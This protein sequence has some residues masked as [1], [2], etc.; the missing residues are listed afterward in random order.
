MWLATLPVVLYMNQV[1]GF[2]DE[3]VMKPVWLLGVLFG[4]AIVNFLE[5]GVEIGRSANPVGH[6]FPEGACADFARPGIPEFC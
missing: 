5:H 1:T 6:A 4:P 2:F 3:V